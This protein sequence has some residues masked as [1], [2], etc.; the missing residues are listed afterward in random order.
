MIYNSAENPPEDL[1]NDGST[2]ATFDIYNS[3][4]SNQYELNSF[5]NMLTDSEYKANCVKNFGRFN[6]IESGTEINGRAKSIF[7]SLFQFDFLSSG[8]C[9]TRLPGNY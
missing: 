4:I 3:R 2:T 8:L 9:W 6:N 5:E 1:I 7:K